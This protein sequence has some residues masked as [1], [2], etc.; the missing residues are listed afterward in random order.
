MSNRRQ[1]LKSVPIMVAAA[2]AVGVSG[3]A[4]AQATVE[5]NDTHAISLGY[6]IDTTKVDKAKYP[7]HDAS[8]YCGNCALYQGGTASTGRCP[9]FAGKVVE[10]K[11]W[12]SAWAKKA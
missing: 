1:F 7:K 5:E 6:K 4:Y 11:G 3:L 9:L 12:C 2:S 8:Q 10:N